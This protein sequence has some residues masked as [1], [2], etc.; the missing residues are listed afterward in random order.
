MTK[1]EE[2][3]L[4]RNLNGKYNIWKAEKYKSYFTGTIER[5]LR[6]NQNKAKGNLLHFI[7]EKDANLLYWLGGED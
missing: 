3:K 6:D 7:K 4:F 2:L 1:E 5:N